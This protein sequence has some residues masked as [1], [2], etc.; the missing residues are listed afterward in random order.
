MKT[1]DIMV[2]RHIPSCYL[3]CQLCQPKWYG[4]CHTELPLKEKRENYIGIETT[5]YIN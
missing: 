2:S 1:S 4:T 3:Y 5:P